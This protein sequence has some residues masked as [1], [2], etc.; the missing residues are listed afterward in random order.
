M[1]SFIPQSIA[2]WT[3]ILTGL[4]IIALRVWGIKQPRQWIEWAEAQFVHVR[5][6]RVIGITLL[7]IGISSWILADFPEGFLGALYIFSL[8]FLIVLGFM[9]AVTQ[10]HLRLFVMATAESDDKWIRISSIITSL[11][12][13]LILLVP[14]L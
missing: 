10:N 5:S 3:V 14:W 9:F 8:G 7:L 2:E 4:L 11:A 1:S 13:I 12:G 6:L